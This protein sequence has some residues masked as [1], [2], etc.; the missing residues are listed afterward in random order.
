MQDKIKKIDCV[1]FHVDSLEEW[2][3]FYWEKMWLE[4][5][6]KTEIEAGFKLQNSET[7]LVIQTQRQ[8]QEIAFTVD[9][10]IKSVKEFKKIGANILVEPFDINIWKCAVIQD[11]WWNVFSILD[12]TKWFYKTDENGNVVGIESELKI[13]N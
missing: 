13:K 2:I 4:L 12:N 11:N 5:I 10:V 1:C 7:E 6:W 3:K 9:D 8:W